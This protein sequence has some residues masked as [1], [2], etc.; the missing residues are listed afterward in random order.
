MLLHGVLVLLL[1]RAYAGWKDIEVEQMLAYLVGA[2]AV[3]SR[4]VALPAPPPAAARRARAL[5]VPPARAAIPRESEPLAAAPGDTAQPG[6]PGGVP[7]GR[8]G[9]LAGLALSPRAGDERLWVRPMYIPEG[10]G[11]PIS[12]D[13]VVRARLLTMA[14][15]ADS[16]SRLDSLNPSVNPYAPPSW[17]FE[18]NGRT[19]GI[20]AQGI[21]LGTFTIPTA[22]LA[23]LP[24]PQ[25]NVDQARLNARLME[26]R[27]DLL[28]A[29]ARAEAEDD[30]RRAVQQIRA[31]RDRER[32]EQRERERRRRQAEGGDQ[33]IP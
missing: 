33:P 20:D 30:F 17:T 16:L 1:L 32:Q 23:F 12:M 31:R 18:R 11:R 13:S 22:V 2:P 5:V 3:T 10:G 27:A 25:G 21:H 9:G 29:A 24:L 28:R 26:M 8:P 14:Q 7:G 19:Y 15:L 6:E 4:P